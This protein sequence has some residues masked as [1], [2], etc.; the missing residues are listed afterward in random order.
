MGNW[1]NDWINKLNKT[2][3][4]VKA[5]DEDETIEQLFGK[6]Y[7]PDEIYEWVKES[8]LT[9][10]CWDSTGKHIIKRKFVIPVGNMSK[11]DAEKTLAGMIADY[12]EEIT[13]DDNFGTVQ[14]NGS[15]NIPYNKEYWFPNKF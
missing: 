10:V 11:D 6:E 15:P 1:M 3:Q 9:E 13:F 14:V 12:K 2:K 7:H 5:K 8:D 4:N